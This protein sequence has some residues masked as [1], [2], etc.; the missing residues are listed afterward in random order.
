M[1]SA[2]HSKEKTWYSS[3]NVVGKSEYVT[4]PKLG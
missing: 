3:E 4:A 2:D 1:V